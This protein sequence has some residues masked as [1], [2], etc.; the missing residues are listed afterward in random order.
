MMKDFLNN[1]YMVNWKMVGD[2]YIN[3]NLGS[4]TALELLSYRN[5][6]QLLIERGRHKTE[7]DGGKERKVVVRSLKERA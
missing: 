2:Q 4:R 7:M 1:F 3:T 5:L 6:F